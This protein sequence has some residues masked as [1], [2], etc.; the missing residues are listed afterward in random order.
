MSNTCAQTRPYCKARLTS[1]FLT[2]LR[3]PK[4]NLARPDCF[5]ALSVI[6]QSNVTHND[7]SVLM[8][9]SIKFESAWPPLQGLVSLITSKT[10]LSHR[11]AVF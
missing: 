8:L 4:P 2:V 9:V 10:N 1:G 6:A 7:D 11:I 5:L 3:G